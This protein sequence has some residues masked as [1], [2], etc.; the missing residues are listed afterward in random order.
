MTATR[1]EILERVKWRRVDCERGCEPF[2]VPPEPEPVAKGGKGAPPPPPATTEAPLLPMTPEGTVDE[3]RAA[4][5]Q[6]RHDDSQENVLRRLELWDLYCEEVCSHAGR[7][8]ARG[9]GSV[10]AAHLC[11]LWFPRGAPD[12]RRTPACVSPCLPAW[13]PEAAVDQANLIARM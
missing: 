1:A 10:A 7:C 11:A 13:R 12:P 8:F 2:H 9:L 3:S 4:R 6:P 5:L